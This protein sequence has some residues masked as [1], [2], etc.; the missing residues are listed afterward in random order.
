MTKSNDLARRVAALFSA[1]RYHPLPER[2][3]AKRLQLAPGQRGLLRQILR[4]LQQQG[5][6]APLSGGRWGAAPASAAP[7]SGTY[8]VRMNGS[9]WLVPDGPKQPPM[10]IDPASAGVA[11]NGDQIQAVPIRREAFAR[12]PGA[13]PDTQAVR[14]V[15][16]VKRKRQWVVGLLQATPHH[17]FVAP[18]DPLLRTPIR[19]VDS[20]AKL[21][22]H[23][24]HLVVAR[25][26]EDDP[27]AGQPVVAKFAEDLGDPDDAA[28]D[29]P[30]LLKDRGLEETF[31]AEVT[32]AAR[33]SR[34]HLARHGADPRGRVDL[35]GDLIVAIDPADA[36]DHDDAVSIA[37]LPGGRWKLGVHIADVA[38]YVEPGSA[39][40]REAL[41]RGNSTYLVDRVVRMLPRDLTVSTC[42]LLPG[43][44]HLAH[45]AEIVYDGRGHVLETKTFRSIIR[46]RAV[47]AYEQVQDFFDTGRFPGAAADLLAALRHLRDLAQK[48]RALRFANGALDFALPEAHCVLDAA[49]QPVGFVRRGATEA[50]NL[51]EECMLAANQAVARKVHAAGVPGIYRVHDEPSEEQWARMAAELRA[52]GHRAAPGNAQDLNRIVRSVQGRPEQYMTTLTLLRNMM[53]ATYEAECRPHFGLGFTH[54]AHFTSPI[55]RYPDL[56]LHR[57]LIGLEE[58][59]KTPVYSAAEIEKLALH[60][61]GTERESAE[62]ESQSLQIKRLRY[63][64]TL[65]A[66]GETGPFP[67]TVISL[68][69]KGLIVELAESLQQG[70]LPYHAIGRD[71]FALADDGLSASARGGATFRLG[72]AIA[73]GLAAVDETA[74]RVDF[75]LPG[76]A[77]RAERRPA[78]RPAAEKSPH[79]PVDKRPQMT[80]NKPSGRPARSQPRRKQR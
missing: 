12:I 36:H 56:V 15:R 8:C 18:R 50:Y 30:A 65:L 67:G 77:R 41:R 69:P 20:L 63:F 48:I 55:R 74:R 39:I 45:T 29:V 60:C 27:A 14:L 10:W 11:M 43:E 19:L 59:R 16:I 23:L 42:S 33:H 32:K 17:A 2:D 9:G 57:I 80:G 35:R 37:P 54:Y 58:G 25:I 26:V 51:I 34:E 72:Q 61:S 13:R 6:A 24:G 71:W 76:A 31:P 75:F 52:L 70:M 21:E 73:V 46:T 1:P 44:D 4:E 40:D 68:N 78:R 79:N 38:A 5:Q 49:G 53:R 66:K 22:P 3:L 62:L 64:A 7:I 47:L 28:N